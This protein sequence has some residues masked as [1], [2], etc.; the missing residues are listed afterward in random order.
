MFY[1]NA[2]SVDSVS[3]KVEHEDSNRT[4]DVRMPLTSFEF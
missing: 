1:L 3:S 2:I 4:I